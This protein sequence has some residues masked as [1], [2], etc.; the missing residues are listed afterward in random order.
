MN[1]YLSENFGNIDIYLFDQ[2]LKGR[3]DQC[4]NVL[5]VGCGGGRNIVYFL[6]NGFQVYG[7]DRD[8]HVIETVKTLAKELAPNIPSE[9][10]IVTKVEDM[11]FDDSFFNLVI[12]SAMLHFANDYDHFD[13]MLRSIW[14]TLAPG[15]FLFVRLASD[16]G[17]ETLVKNVGN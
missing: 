12:C 4:K 17:I 5:D 1:K 7:I 15:G 10:F 3:F 16:I 6:K 11:P 13:K 9:N 2:L 14:R 8:A